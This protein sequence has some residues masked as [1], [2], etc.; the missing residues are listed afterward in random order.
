MIIIEV[1]II[2][3]LGFMSFQ[4]F[5]YRAIVW[6]LFPITCTLFVIKG[7]TELDTKSYIVN[8]LI[9]FA[10]IILLLSISTAYFSFKNKKP[11]NIIDKYFGSGDIL[12][13]LLLCTVFPPLNLIVFL[14]AALLLI[15]FSFTIIRFFFTC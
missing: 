3:L 11:T 9:N 7:L 12:F 1:L 8:L 5:K 6:L 10:F 14:I 15:L 2:G 13:F 4:D